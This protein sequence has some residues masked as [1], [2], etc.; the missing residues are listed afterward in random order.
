MENTIGL[1]IAMM[2]I[3][4]FAIVAGV[5]AAARFAFRADRTRAVAYLAPFLACCL[6]ILCAALLRILAFSAVASEAVVV[7]G[8]LVVVSG[9]VMACV[10]DRTAPKG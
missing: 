2:L 4:G 9:C 7:C 3:V 1:G 5:L 6:G 10:P 8:L